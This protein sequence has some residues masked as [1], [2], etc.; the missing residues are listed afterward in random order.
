MG[1]SGGA[2]SDASTAKGKTK[3]AAAAKSKSVKDEAYLQAVIQKR[4]GLFESI[5]S[6][7]LAK[8]QSIGGDPIK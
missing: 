4:I 5:Q 2:G 8:R 3:V 6:A 1:E 7:Q